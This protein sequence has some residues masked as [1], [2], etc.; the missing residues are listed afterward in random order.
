MIL[1]F[2]VGWWGGVVGWGAIA[3]NSLETH[4]MLRFNLQWDG[5]GGVRRNNVRF[6]R[7]SLDA[8]AKDTWKSPRYF[9]GTLYFSS[10]PGL[11]LI[12]RL[13]NLSE[14]YKRCRGKRAKRC[15]NQNAKRW[16]T[17]WQIVEAIKWITVHW[18]GPQPSHATS[19]TI[20]NTWK[21]PLTSCRLL[22]LID[23]GSMKYQQYVMHVGPCWPPELLGTSWNIV[24]SPRSSQR[25]RGPTCF[26]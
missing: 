9:E 16:R 15:S 10:Y 4:L 2:M 21:Y 22:N 19:L 12:R 23:H 1:K 20:E 5:G 26:W 14:R 7:N 18:L 8:K 24:K 17:R 13:L 6:T 11:N 3:F 25:P